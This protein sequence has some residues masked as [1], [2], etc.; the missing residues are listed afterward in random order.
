[1]RE[2]EKKYFCQGKHSLN[3]GSLQE[4]KE[5]LEIEKELEEIK[6]ENNIEPVKEIKEVTLKENE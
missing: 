5:E 1:M 4:L 2:F 6:V 3:Y